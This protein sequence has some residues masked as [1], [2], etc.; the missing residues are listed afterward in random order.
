[1][2]FLKGKM[3]IA[4][5]IHPHVA[6]NLF[7]IIIL[8]KTKGEFLKNLQAAHFYLTGYSDRVNIALF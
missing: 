4:L 5:L 1:M 3:K 6:S 7:Y 2:F 8:W